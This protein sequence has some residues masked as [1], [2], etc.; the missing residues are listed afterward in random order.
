M[1]AL[2]DAKLPLP[3]AIS[4]CPIAEEAFAPIT[5]EKIKLINYIADLDQLLSG[6]RTQ[7]SERL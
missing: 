1:R 3:S 6:M 4:V 7:Q 5:E 2:L